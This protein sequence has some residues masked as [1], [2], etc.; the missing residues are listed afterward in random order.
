[1]MKL[2][3]K[4]ISLSAI[5]FTAVFIFG[6]SDTLNEQFVESPIV[7]NVSSELVSDS[8]L[9]TSDRNLIEVPVVDEDKGL[10]QLIPIYKNEDAPQI[11]LLP[12]R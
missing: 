6:K 8:H 1:M 5:L 11:K 2:R 7:D 10:V 12:S 9:P 4:Y 3:I